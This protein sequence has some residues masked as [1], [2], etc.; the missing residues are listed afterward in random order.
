MPKSLLRRLVRSRKGSVMLETALM[1][2]ILL[3]LMFGIIDLGR[4]LYTANNLA[5]AARE[6]ARLAA[7]QE[8]GVDSAAVRATV[9]SHFSPFGGAALTDANIILTPTGAAVDKTLA[10]RVTINYPFTWLTPIR[11][12]VGNMANTLH[13]QAEYHIEN[14]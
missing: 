4:A 7:V 10:L 2:I 8:G 5:S 13:G 14:Q 6:G 9:K 3:M 1:L 12:L 11:A